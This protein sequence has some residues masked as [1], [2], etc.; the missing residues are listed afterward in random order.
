[1]APGERAT[2]A[3]H[4]MGG[5][6][7]S[8]WASHYRHKVAERADAVALINT[9]TG[10]LLE[11]VKLLRVPPPLAS[12]RVAT[13]GRILRRFAGLPVVHA[14]DP[15]SRRFIAAMAVGRDADP[16]IAAFVHE[17]FADTPRRGRGGCAANL[18]DSLGPQH[19]D[20]T[21]L[22]VPTLVIGSRKD[23]LLPLVS[24]R[25]IAMAA[26][27]LTEFVELT[28]GHCSILER[29][30]E[31]NRQLRALVESVIERQAASS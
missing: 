26:P 22:T 9:T 3:G 20:L 7:I 14:V 29:P 13:A 28:G 17:L 23:R 12:T 6:T 11:E 10:Q 21:G 19:L 15:A 2:I 31:V 5:I 30:R 1:L 4:S 18:I 25:R 16:S 27:N 8:S 24:S